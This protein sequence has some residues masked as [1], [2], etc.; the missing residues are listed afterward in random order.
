MRATTQMVIDKM[1]NIVELIN[2]MNNDIQNK[3]NIVDSKINTLQQQFDSLSK[4]SYSNNTFNHS[5]I[6][7]NNK[8]D[9]LNEN[10]PCSNIEGGI[11]NFVYTKSIDFH[12]D[13]SIT[14]ILYKHI[15]LFEYVADVISH[16]IETCEQNMK[17]IHCFEYQKNVI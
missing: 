16:I 14:D 15:S 4:E 11:L 17:F 10:M 6:N 1:D 2:A 12:R 8:E 5:K 3:I 9:Y 7:P 13:S